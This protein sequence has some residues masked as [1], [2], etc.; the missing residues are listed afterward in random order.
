MMRA[1]KV[2]PRYR[3][4]VKWPSAFSSREDVVLSTD[5]LFDLRPVGAL[6]A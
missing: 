5:L 3:F 2:R 1:A 4:A 6:A